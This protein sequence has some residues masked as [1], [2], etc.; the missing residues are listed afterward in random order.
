MTSKI[1]RSAGHHVPAAACAETGDH[2]GGH[3]EVHPRRLPCGDSGCDEQTGKVLQLV[4]QVAGSHDDVD[5]Q[6]FSIVG[7]QLWRQGRRWFRERHQRVPA[8]GGSCSLPS[9]LWVA[10]GF[11][12]GR[13]SST[14]A[15]CSFRSRRASSCSRCKRSCSIWRKRRFSCSRCRC[16]TALATTQIRFRV[17]LDSTQT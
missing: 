2:L 11:P 4:G 8:R 9:I 14:A 13:N 7:H 17:V 16:W 12:A 5:P 10:L 3:V 15:R 6:Q 1:S